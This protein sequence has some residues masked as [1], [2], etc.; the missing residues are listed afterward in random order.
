M[1][2]AAT[3][4]TG[5]T[6]RKDGTPLP[7]LSPRALRLPVAASLLLHVSV[8]AF[9]LSM[10]QTS[11]T[12]APQGLPDGIS[13]TFIELAAPAAA[14]AP[15]AAPPPVADVRPRP[16]ISPAP[17]AEAVPLPAPVAAEL[18]RKPAPQPRL[19]EARQAP[20]ETETASAAA[21]SASSHAHDGVG[22]AAASGM[23]QSPG[24]ADDDIIIT[25]PRYR[26]A[27]RPPVYP[28]RARDLG[29][30]GTAMIRVKLDLA[31]NPAEV[32][33]L[34][35]SGYALLDH[36]AIRA[37]RGWQFEPERRGGRPVAAFVH[38]PVRFALN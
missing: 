29:Q 5:S 37:A 22:E 17:V 34:E 19:S 15:A 18:E 31:G 9:L 3:A 10:W 25:E 13:V 35:S 28:R 30:E 1:S 33:L 7:S 24:E 27:P 2:M 6:A 32:S 12:K 26:S 20:P 11:G 8:A 36:A 38:I 23:T 14:N 16:D 4:H 21:S